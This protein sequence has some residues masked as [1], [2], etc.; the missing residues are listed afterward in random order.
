MKNKHDNNRIKNSRG[1]NQPNVKKSPFSAY[2]PLIFV[3]RGKR[4]PN[5]M[6]LL[7]NNQHLETYT[8]M[9]HIT[10][11]KTAQKVFFFFKR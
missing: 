4:K 1:K 9:F 6:V 3:L 7:L 11:K 8:S 5:F 10:E 2:N